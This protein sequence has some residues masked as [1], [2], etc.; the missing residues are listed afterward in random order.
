MS[1][2]KKTT[3]ELQRTE[4]ESQKFPFVLLLDQV[5]SGQ[6][7]GSLFRSADAFGADHIHLCGITVQPPHREILKTALGAT[8]TVAWT[9]HETSIEAINTVKGMG[10]S[11]YALEQAHDST[12]LD[13]WSWSMETRGVALIVGNEVKGVD[14]K[15]LEHCDGVLEITQVGQKHSLNVAVS[16]GIAMHHIFQTFAAR[17]SQK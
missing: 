15:L 6:N 2:R 12:S 10:Y 13:E 16:A 11:V 4:S 1:F 7:V 5:R 14:Q 17:E 8:Q 3:Q 9:Y